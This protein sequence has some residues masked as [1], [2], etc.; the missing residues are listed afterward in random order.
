MG[1][2]LPIFERTDEGIFVAPAAANVAYAGYFKPVWSP[3]LS[4][5]RHQC[6]VGSR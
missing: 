1:A 6:R 5:L 4:L 3:D 2:L